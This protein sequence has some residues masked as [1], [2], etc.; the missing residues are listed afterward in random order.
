MFVERPRPW[1]G[2]SVT[3]E[4]QYV[5]DRLLAAAIADEQAGNLDA[6]AAWRLHAEEAGRHAPTNPSGRSV[7]G[8]DTQRVC[9]SDGDPWPCGYLKHQVAPWREQEGFPKHLL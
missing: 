5:L 4:L 8:S 9:A 3:D 1:L 7:V 6:A 2:G